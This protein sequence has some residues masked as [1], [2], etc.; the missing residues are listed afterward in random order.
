[1]KKRYAEAGQYIVGDFSE[2]RLVQG[3]LFDS[4]GERLEKIIIGK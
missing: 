3:W 4:S 2:G 1:M